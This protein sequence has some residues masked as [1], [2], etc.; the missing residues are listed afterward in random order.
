MKLAP[1]PFNENERVKTVI[2]TGLIDSL[3]PKCFRFIVI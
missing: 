2:K 3:I 1:V